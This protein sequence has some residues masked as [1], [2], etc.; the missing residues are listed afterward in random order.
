MLCKI[1]LRDTENLKN[2]TL[3][4]NMMSESLLEDWIVKC[5]LLEKLVL[6]GCTRLEIFKIS[7]EK[8]KSLALIKCVNLLDADI[9]A[10]NL[11]S[12]EYNGRP[13]PFRSLNAR[14]LSQLKLSIP[15]NLIK[16]IFGD[17]DGIEGLKLILYSKKVH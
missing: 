2:L 15:P 7:S 3:K 16:D 8:L 12:F 11:C 14:H 6:H 4:D 17:F 1:N 13:M 10:P 9:D 5:P